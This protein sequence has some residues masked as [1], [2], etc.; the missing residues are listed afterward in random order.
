MSDIKAQ[1]A[2]E[3][4]LAAKDRSQQIEMPSQGEQDTPAE[5]EPE[6]IPRY[7]DE[8]LYR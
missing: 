7:V 2:H 8:P 4:G 1:E 6:E 5:D 3:K